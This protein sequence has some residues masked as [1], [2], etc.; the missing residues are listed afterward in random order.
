M[1]QSIV[2]KA[3]LSN[4]KNWTK[5]RK[6]DFWGK[7]GRAGR[8]GLSGSKS[9]IGSFPKWII[10]TNHHTKFQTSISKRVKVIQLLKLDQNCKELRS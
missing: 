9:I 1:S 4:R 3:K 6:L 7:D 8:G 2:I 5:T 10:M